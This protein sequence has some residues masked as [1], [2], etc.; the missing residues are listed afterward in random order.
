M[1]RKLLVF[2]LSEL[3]KVRL[4]CQ[5]PECGMV[6]ELDIHKM[7]D[8]YSGDSPQCP[9]CRTVLW[10]ERPGEDNPFVTFANAAESLI[11]MRDRVEIEFVLPD[12]GE[13]EN[14]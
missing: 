4:I 13:S 3:G 14:A 7:G 6:V 5:R 2:L 12:N 1:S 8:R 9:G 11:A 10:R